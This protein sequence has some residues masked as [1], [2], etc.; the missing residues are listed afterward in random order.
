MF[1]HISDDDESED[2]TKYSV[3]NVFLFSSIFSFMF[4][5]ILDDDECGD[6]ATC[7]CQPGLDEHGCE[8]TCVNLEGRYRCDCSEGYVWDNNNTCQGMTLR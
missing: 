4:I 3:N 7:V 6:A 5:H 8:A 2:A 1:I